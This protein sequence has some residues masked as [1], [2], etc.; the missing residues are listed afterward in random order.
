MSSFIRTAKLTARQ[1]RLPQKTLPR[2]R[3][4]SQTNR[5]MGVHNL[6]NKAEYDDAIA[7]NRVVVLDAYAAPFLLPRNQLKDYKL[8]AIRFATWCGPCKVI[9]PKIVE[10]VYPSSSC[11]NSHLRMQAKAN[12]HSR[13]SDSY[14]DAH[15][16]KIDVDE[17]PDVAQELN[18]R[19]MPT[20][21]IFK[22]GKEVKRVVGAS[23]G[24]VENA[25]SATIKE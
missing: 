18:I 4:F 10:Y 12:L 21:V 17:V 2:N 1:Y 15:F 22:D 14:S 23:P 11:L 16:V 3:Y 13:F 19:A 6:A 24:D 7:N 20:F 9:A 8:T 5:I 25:I